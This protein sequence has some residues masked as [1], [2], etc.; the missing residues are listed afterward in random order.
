MI[1]GSSPSAR[2]HSAIPDSD[3][4]TYRV[5]KWGYDT[6]EDAFRDIDR[7]KTSREYQKADLVVMQHVDP[8]AAA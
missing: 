1:P 2:F 4:A 3:A 5:V 7:L 6:A 8:D